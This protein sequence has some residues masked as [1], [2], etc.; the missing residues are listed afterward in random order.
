VRL[1]LLKFCLT[2]RNHCRWSSVVC[3]LAVGVPL[4]VW[5]CI[6]AQRQTDPRD[7]PLA[8]RQTAFRVRSDF[9]SALNG[10]GG[11]AGALN[12]NVTV[13]VDQP[14][15]IRFE[16]EGSVDAS[17]EQAF[18]LQ[19]RR[20][21]GEWSNVEAEDFPVPDEASPQ[22]SI[23]STTA[24]KQ[25][26]ATTDLLPQSTAAYQDGAGISLADRAATEDETLD[27]V[28]NFTR[29]RRAS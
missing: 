13:H 18:R 25:G 24:Y 22:V 14:F 28:R 12:K 27:S 8:V 21:G 11:W 3:V 19:C 23:V 5:N 10:N 20:N 2:S 4:G 17:D 1:H 9:N 7:K 6:A 16:L 26:V 29:C 15:R